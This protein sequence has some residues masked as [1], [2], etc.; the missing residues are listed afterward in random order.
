MLVLLWRRSRAWGPGRCRS[1]LRSSLRRLPLARLAG[2]ER[3]AW[4]PWALLVGTSSRL[5]APLATLGCTTMR[6]ARLRSLPPF[7]ATRPPRGMPTR[8]G[9]YP[10]FPSRLPHHHYAQPP[11]LLFFLDHRTSPGNPAAFSSHHT[12]LLPSSTNTAQ[13]SGNSA[14]SSSTR[15]VLPRQVPQFC[16]QKSA[17]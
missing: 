10:W 5:G 17:Y 7:L 11:C 4:V 2:E 12:L 1:R 6:A 16:Q 14:A 13:S 3:A 15:F 9:K 8:S